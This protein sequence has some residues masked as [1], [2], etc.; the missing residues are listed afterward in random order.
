MKDARSLRHCNR[1]EAL[2]TIQRFVALAV[3]GLVP[4]FDEQKRAVL[5]HLEEDRL[6][7]PFGRDFPRGIP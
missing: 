3:R 5:L 4:M 7:Y 1:M 2:T 6:G